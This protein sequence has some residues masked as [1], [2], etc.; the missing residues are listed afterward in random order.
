MIDAN[1]FCQHIYEADEPLSLSGFGNKRQ[2]KSGGIKTAVDTSPSTKVDGKP[3]D[4]GKGVGCSYDKSN[5]PVRSR[6]GSVEFPRPQSISPT[7]PVQRIKGMWEK[8]ILDSTRRAQSMQR[9]G[10]K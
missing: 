7:N 3:F 8:S 9:P 4:N 6:P 10:K 2:T 5:D 1:T